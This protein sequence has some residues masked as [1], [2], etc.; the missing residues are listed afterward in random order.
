MIAIEKDLKKA[1]SIIE[2]NNIK[3]PNV[4]ADSTFVEYVTCKLFVIPTTV[5]VD[6]QGHVI[7][8]MI[9]SACSKEEY[10]NIIKDILADK[11]D[12][13]VKDSNISCSIDGKCEIK[14]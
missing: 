10:I 5:F 3:Y 11:T 7:G 6:N 12:F 8:E 14:R 13:K 2:E 4:F 9:E 1:I